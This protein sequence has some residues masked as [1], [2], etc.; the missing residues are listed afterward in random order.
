MFASYVDTDGTVYYDGLLEDYPIQL[1][2]PLTLLDYE[3]MRDYFLY[4]PFG[5]YIVKDLYDQCQGLI[6]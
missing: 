3:D 4:K 2:Y 5:E 6:I 1:D